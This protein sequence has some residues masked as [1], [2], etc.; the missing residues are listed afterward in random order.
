MATVNESNTNHDTDDQRYVYVLTWE[1]NNGSCWE[2]GYMTPLGV[3]SS[4]AAAVAAAGTVSVPG[5]GTFDE[6]IAENGAENYQDYRNAPATDEDWEGVLLLEYDK[7]GEYFNV[8]LRKH[9]LE[10]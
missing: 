2:P 9:I 1:T 6:A 4:R 5:V 10:D 7:Y 8:Y 3:Y